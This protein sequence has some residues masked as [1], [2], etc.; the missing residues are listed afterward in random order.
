[1]LECFVW[2]WVWVRDA[3]AKLLQ[4]C[5][6]VAVAFVALF[7]RR[8]LAVC[9]P[10]IL[11]LWLEIALLLVESVDIKRFRRGKDTVCGL[12]CMCVFVFVSAYCVLEC[13]CWGVCLC[14]W[15]RDLEFWMLCVCLQVCMSQCP[16]VSSIWVSNAEASDC[17]CPRSESQTLK[18][19][20]HDSKSCPLKEEFR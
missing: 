20:K 8:P 1:M 16:C 11:A 3:Y 19:K 12:Q 6:F 18:K 13:L 5:W 2:V 15:C 9:E 10:E 17:V 7:S 14:V 4:L